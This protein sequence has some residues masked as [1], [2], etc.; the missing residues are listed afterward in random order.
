MKKN[1]VGVSEYTDLKQQIFRE[2]LK[3]HIRIVKGILSRNEWPDQRYWYIDLTAGPGKYDG[4]VGSPVIFHEEIEKAGM[5]YSAIL[6]EREQKFHESLGKYFEEMKNSGQVT[7]E[8]EIVHKPYQEGKKDT[9]FKRPRYGLVYIDPSG[10]MPDFDYLG[11]ISRYKANQYMDFLINISATNVKRIR[12]S[13]DTDFSENLMELL[14][15][16]DKKHWLVREP[17]AKHQWTMLIGTN[18]D[19]FPKFK[20]RRFFRT[21]EPDGRDILQR[22]SMTTSEYEEA[23]QLTLFN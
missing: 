3:M 6:F 4:H 20:G 10:D 9:N 11:D 19:A 14:G 18:W 5:P 13:P 12:K 8:V 16:L 21:N 15:K 1:D 2:L 22:L 23:Y 17:Y 7:G